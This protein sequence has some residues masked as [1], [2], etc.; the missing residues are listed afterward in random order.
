M[1]CDG[2]GRPTV[3][4]RND[5]VHIVPPIRYPDMA[6]HDLRDLPPLPA[7]EWSAEVLRAYGVIRQ[8][9]T[10][11][12]QLASRDENNP[13]RLCVA[14]DSLVEKSRILDELAAAVGDD[15]WRRALIQAVVPLESA[16][17]V[18]SVSISLR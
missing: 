3:G 4:G 14:A 10:H 16:L 7:G 11:C 6:E 8:A 18:G 15:E 12:R 17:R 9:F 13:L 2:E 5:G 1:D